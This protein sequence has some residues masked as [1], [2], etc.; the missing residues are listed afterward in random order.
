MTTDLSSFSLWQKVKVAGG[1][2]Q[3]APR[4][5]PQ[6]PHFSSESEDVSTCGGAENMVHAVPRPWEDD[7]GG[8]REGKGDRSPWNMQETHMWPH[9]GSRKGMVKLSWMA[10]FV[11]FGAGAGVHH[12]FTQKAVFQNKISFTEWYVFQRSLPQVPRWRHIKNWCFEKKRSPPKTTRLKPVS[13]LCQ[14]P[15]A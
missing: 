6:N 11:V 12:G 14:L 7:P 3:G 5:W 15:S 4:L 10:A 9:V 2:P 1:Q 13:K 8:Y